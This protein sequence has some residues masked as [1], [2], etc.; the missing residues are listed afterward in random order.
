MLG[1]HAAQGSDGSGE[2]L[3]VVRQEG[4]AGS[5]QTGVCGEKG[6]AKEDED[7][8]TQTISL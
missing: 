5:H 4:E 7:H 6:T 3:V 2:Q 8:N 1:D